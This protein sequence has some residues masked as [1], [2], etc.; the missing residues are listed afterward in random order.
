MG[1]YG[2][3]TGAL[4]VVCNDKEDADKVLSQVKRLIRVNY[5]SPP[6]HGARIAGLILSNTEMRK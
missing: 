6:K 5:S 4:H 3:R 1:L 2:E